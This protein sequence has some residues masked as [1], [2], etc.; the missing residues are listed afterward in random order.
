MAELS[1]S[2]IKIY[3]AELVRRQSFV[4]KKLL[5]RLLSQM[6]GLKALHDMRIIHFDLKPENVLVCP[7]GH[8]SIADFGFSVSWLDPRYRRYPSHDLR[9][10]RLGGTDG[11]MAPEMIS[12]LQNPSGAYQNSFGFAADI[13]SMGVVIAELGLGG[14][15]LVSFN[16]EELGRWKDDYRG[17]ACQMVLSRE[18]LMGR[19]RERLRGGHAMLVEE[20]RVIIGSSK[21][22]DDTNSSPTKMLEPDEASRP[23]FDVIFSHPFFSGLDFGR[24]LGRGYLG[25]NALVAVA[26]EF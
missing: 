7:D 15:R 25:M 5:T 17:F 21:D 26:G 1:S 18:Q 16:E 10:R 20:V 23:Y 19:V 13:W 14:D 3:A 8:L 4:T 11:Y 12:A 22:G 24:I 6:Y 9:G 2:A